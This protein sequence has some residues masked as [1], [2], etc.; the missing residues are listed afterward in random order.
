[1]ITVSEQNFLQRFL[2]L[3][4]V[5]ELEVLR[6]E[7]CILTFSLLGFGDLCSGDSKPFTGSSGRGDRGLDLIFDCCL[8]E[9]SRERVGLGGSLEAFVP[10]TFG[11]S[12]DTEVLCRFGEGSIKPNPWR[13]L[14]NQIFLGNHVEN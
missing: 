1:L 12:G 2:C 3:L 8:G 9:G 5:S 6:F 14:V 4:F 11:G 10:E 7:E 13:K